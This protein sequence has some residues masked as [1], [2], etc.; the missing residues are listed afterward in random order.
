MEVMWKDV[1]ENS[2]FTSDYWENMWKHL[3][4]DYF[5]EFIERFTSTLSS[6]LMLYVKR[7]RNILFKHNMLTQGEDEE[8]GTL[9]VTGE[10][11]YYDERR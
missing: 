6:I 4:Y 1:L 3:G 11:E 9:R 2:Y 8:D 10:D 7:Q 5:P